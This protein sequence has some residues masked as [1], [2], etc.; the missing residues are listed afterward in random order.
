MVSLIDGLAGMSD[1]LLVWIVA[2]VQAALEVRVGDRRDPWA[3]LV[4]SPGVSLRWAHLDGCRGLC[5]RR[6]DGRYVITLEETLGRAERRAVL[7][8]ELAHIDLGTFWTDHTP[9]D[10]IEAGEVATN[11][12]AVELFDF[13]VSLLSATGARSKQLQLDVG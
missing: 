7:A 3:V 5:E 1:E 9:L 4:R 13:D 2:G 8:H 12:R 10:E 6:V 11:A